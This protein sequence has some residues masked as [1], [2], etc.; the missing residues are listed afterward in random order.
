MKRG[1]PILLV[2]VVVLAS[3]A[4]FLLVR[5]GLA[6]PIN[7]SKWNSQLALSYL[8]G[9]IKE[10]HETTGEFPA[11]LVGLHPGTCASMR[12]G[13]SGRVGG[14]WMKGYPDEAQV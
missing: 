12:F 3:A 8:R 1:L 5:Y 10:Y 6:D 11:S 7:Q 13:V 14:H 2:L 9:K 4:S